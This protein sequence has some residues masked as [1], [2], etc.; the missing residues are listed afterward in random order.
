MIFKKRKMSLNNEKENI[1]LMERKNIDMLILYRSLYILKKKFEL[2]KS[3]IN[4]IYQDNK[5][6]STNLL[7]LPISNIPQILKNIMMIA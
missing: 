6:K 1:N 2:Y 3:Q 7:V 5:K 4:Q